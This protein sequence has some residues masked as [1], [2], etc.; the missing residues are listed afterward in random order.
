MEILV[1]FLVMLFYE[2]YKTIMGNILCHALLL[3]A[4]YLFYFSLI[5]PAGILEYIFYSLDS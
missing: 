1:L 2:E 5:S 4:Y 3:L